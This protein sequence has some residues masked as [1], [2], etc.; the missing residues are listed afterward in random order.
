[1]R[2]RRGRIHCLRKFIDSRFIP[3]AFKQLDFT[4]TDIDKSDVHDY[5]IYFGFSSLFDELKEGELIPEYRIAVSRNE[6]EKLI[7]KATRVVT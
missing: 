4:P 7:F 6:D 3:E 5:W 2:N 1:M